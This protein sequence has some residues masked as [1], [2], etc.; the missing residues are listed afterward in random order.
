[1][2]HT[3]LRLKRVFSK[4][5]EVA[6]KTRLL[7]RSCIWYDVLASTCIRSLCTFDVVYVFRFP[8]NYFT[9]L[10]GIL[11]SFVGLTGLLQYAL[12]EWLEAYD[13]AFTHVSVVNTI[14]TLSIGTFYRLN[15]LV[16]KLLLPVG[17]LK[18]LLEQWQTVQILI[19]MPR[20]VASDLALHSLLRSVCPN[21]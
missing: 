11:S 15:M 19:K 14:F 1:M 5:T 13:G 10:Y 17:V 20:S 4:R 9:E 2:L 21:T 12:F 6:P 7:F 16:L 8:L 3:I 18:I